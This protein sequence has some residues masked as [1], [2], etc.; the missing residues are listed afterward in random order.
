MGKGRILHFGF[1][2]AAELFEAEAVPFRGKKLGVDNHLR[3]IAIKHGLASLSSPMVG[4]FWKALIMLN[5]QFLQVG[6]WNGYAQLRHSSY[7]TYLNPQLLDQSAEVVEDWEE[8]CGYPGIRLMV[9]RAKKV[10][11]K[12]K[13]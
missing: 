13:E 4:E 9:P 2:G 8:C 1:A 6:K 10:I 7:D 11:V 3:N 12:F 5:R